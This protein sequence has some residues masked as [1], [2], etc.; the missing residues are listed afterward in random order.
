MDKLSLKK[1]KTVTFGEFLL[2]DMS[3]QKLMENA[4]I[5]KRHFQGFSNTVFMFSLGLWIKQTTGKLQVTLTRLEK[6]KK[7][8]GMEKT[9]F[10]SVFP[11]DEIDYFTRL[12]APKKA[13]DESCLRPSLSVIVPKIL[14]IVAFLLFRPR[15]IV[16]NLAKTVSILVT[17]DP[18]DFSIRSTRRPKLQKYPRFLHC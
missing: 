18:I 10:Y 12:A 15:S 14:D 2:P 6:C 13:L 4:K 8:K 17:I 16:S 1:P 9:P 3:R 7:G 5:Q 11:K